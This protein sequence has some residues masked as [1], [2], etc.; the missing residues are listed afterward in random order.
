MGYLILD[1]MRKNNKTKYGIESKLYPSLEDYKD[2]R[3]CNETTLL[4]AVAAFI[5]DNCVNLRIDP[6][7]N[8]MALTDPEGESLPGNSIP[9]YM[10]YE[11][12]RLCLEQTLIRFLKHNTTNHA[13]EVYLCYAE[14]FCAQGKGPRNL[15]T[16]LS[17]FEA[18]ASP[19]VRNHRDHYVHSVLVF[20]LGLAI[21]HSS[22]LFRSKYQ[23][24][25]GLSDETAAAHHFLRY[26]GF[27]ALFHDIGYPYELVFEQ[28]KDYN[29]TTR[30]GMDWLPMFQVRYQCAYPEKQ[31]AQEDEDPVDTAALAQSRKEY[32]ETMNR[33][34]LTEAQR[35]ELKGKEHSFFSHLAVSLRDRL[36]DGYGKFSDFDHFVSD[37]PGTK[38]N[39]KKYLQN[40]LR[41]KPVHPEYF[42]GFM[43][44]ALFSAFQMYYHL[45]SIPEQ[46]LCPTYMDALT[47]IV[48]HNSFLK[49]KI[50]GKEEKKRLIKG[51]P[52]L[53]K[54]FD[55]ST[56]PL[57]YMLLLCDDLQCWGRRAYGRLN[58]AKAYP[59]DCDL[60]F[61]GNRIDA[62]FYFSKEDYTFTAPAAG[63]STPIL[64]NKDMF[65]QGFGDLALIL[66]LDQLQNE[67][68]PPSSGRPCLYADCDLAEMD[69]P[70]VDSLSHSSY[71][72]LYDFA[73][74]INSTYRGVNPKVIMASKTFFDDAKNEFEA[75]SLEYK[76]TNVSTAA[77]FAVH[78]KGI[79]CFYTDIPVPFQE[80][81]MLTKNE[82]RTIRNKEFIAWI[83]YKKSLGW[84]EIP[85]SN[86]EKIVEK[87]E[88]ENI[89]EL[90]RLHKYIKDPAA[91][92]QRDGNNH[93]M[94]ENALLGLLEGTKKLDGVRF[95]SM[96][97][98]Y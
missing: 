83:E 51:N 30:G 82:M 22:D 41:Q 33:C 79:G 1:Q 47:A 81:D 8:Y 32:E 25:Y 60:S 94:L 26:W 95:Y 78:L 14:I 76:L 19:L 37:C 17:E 39:Y 24:F 67:A 38:Q 92:N 56:H 57:A 74:V 16:L 34:L 70:P 12:D 69:L 6:N 49:Y 13:Y 44:H 61:T 35:T 3:I 7:S 48:L 65:L 53:P 88:K 40:V 15:L 31:A 27:T 4:G 29:N 87:I 59:F 46:E 91:G 23:S 20:A 73:A 43:D 9:L 50:Y 10:Q 77:R 28:I 64:L 84:D 21:Y 98:L 63:A 71:L 86:R 90:V 93:L 52:P 54:R 62:K 45:D 89:R 72:H 18:N 58:R 96:I 42:K 66:D 5:R 11:L 75:L 97:P 68:D 85:N 80:K 36:Y 55:I 2:P